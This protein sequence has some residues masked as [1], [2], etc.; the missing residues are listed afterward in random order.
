MLFQKLK[1]CAVVLAALSA[2]AL[3]SGGLVLAARPA[4]SSLAVAQE[5]HGSRRRLHRRRLAWTTKNL[6]SPGRTRSRTHP[7]CWRLRARSLP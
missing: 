4:L 5:P 6:R 7:S 2:L 3:V 1:L